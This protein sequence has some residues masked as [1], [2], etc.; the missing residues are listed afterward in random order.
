M[1]AG[2]G[3]RAG[4]AAER[5][6]VLLAAVRELL[7]AVAEQQ[8][9]ASV[10]EPGVPELARELGELISAGEPDVEG[11]F[12]L[13]WLHWHRYV[14]LPE[15]EDELDLELAVEMLGFCFF[16]GITLSSLPQSSLPHLVA[17]VIPDAQRLLREAVDSADAEEI[18]TAVHL[19]A[20]IAEALPDDEPA[21]AGSLANVGAALHARFAQTGAPADLD[22]AIRVTREAVTAMAPGHP[23]RDPGPVQPSLLRL[24]AL[25]PGSRPDRPG[26]GD[27]GGPGGS[28]GYLTR[29]PR[30]GRQ[31]GHSRCHLDDPVRQDGRA[32]GSRC[33]DPG[34]AGCD[35]C[36][37]GRP[38][39]GRRN[40]EPRARLVSA[41]RADRPA[42]GSGG[43]GPVWPRG[44]GRGA[45]R[46]P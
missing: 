35:R 15:G 39:P 30:P 25:R 21:R 27:L 26:R 37:A 14:A 23:A 36:R 41:V 10:L 8:S 43:G 20:Q 6:A 12:Y 18:S 13:G 24:G 4:S 33:G 9:R 46:R 40:G 34:T 7:A 17:N 29:S 44:G 3:R 19:W 28:G 1:R 2:R 31:A 16:A 45:S 11:F 32:G 38:L 22:E 5:R 42:R